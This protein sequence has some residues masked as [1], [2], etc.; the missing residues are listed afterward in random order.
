MLLPFQEPLPRQSTTLWL[1]EPCR[2]SQL[3]LSLKRPLLVEDALPGNLIPLP[4]YPHQRCQRPAAFRTDTAMQHESQR[5]LVDLASSCHAFPSLLH[6]FYTKLSFSHQTF[7][8]WTWLSPPLGHWLSEGSLVLGPAASAAW[9]NSLETQV[10]KNT[11]ISHPSP[12]R[13]KS[14]DHCLSLVLTKQGHLEPDAGEPTASLKASTSRAEIS[15][16]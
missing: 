16:P 3:P 15:L 7:Q 14:E 2:G 13:F 6:S 5:S 12:E 9:G 1:W 4:R 11:D 8:S 10:H